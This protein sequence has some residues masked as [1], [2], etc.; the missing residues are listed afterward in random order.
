MCKVEN[1]IVNADLEKIAKADLGHE[2]TRV[3]LKDF[4]SFGSPIEFRF[5]EGQIIFHISKKE[6]IINKSS[7][8][9]LLP[10]STLGMQ[11]WI[12]S[13]EDKVEYSTCFFYTQHFGPW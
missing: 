9:L 7:P 3:M 11:L 2:Q 4:L 6:K 5:S 8:P 10:M 1:K 13:D 12:C